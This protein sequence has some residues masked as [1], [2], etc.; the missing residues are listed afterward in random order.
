MIQLLIGWLMDIPREGAILTIVR[1]GITDLLIIHQQVNQQ[2][3]RL[4]NSLLCQVIY[5]IAGRN[6]D[7]INGF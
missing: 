7:S 5:R 2:L 4:I 1:D 6:I 3:V